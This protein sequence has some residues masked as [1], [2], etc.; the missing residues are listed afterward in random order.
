[1]SITQGVSGRCSPAS[2]ASL[3]CAYVGTTTLGGLL[4]VWIEYDAGTRTITGVTDTAGNSY[5]ICSAK[6]TDSGGRS[7]YNWCAI[8]TTPAANDTLTFTF[9]GGNSG[10][11]FIIIS[12]HISTNGWNATVTNNVESADTVASG[13]TEATVVTGT[14]NT[15]QASTLA[16]CGMVLSNAKVATATQPTGFTPTLTIAS[17]SSRAHGVW[18]NVTSVQ[19]GIT[20]GGTITSG[21]TFWSITGV[22]YKDVAA[23]SV[24]PRRALVY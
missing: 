4:N 24:H 16:T 17:A 21:G 9:S 13:T 22:V 12:E 20:C 5:S 18:A 10:T 7:Y 19:T 14:F 23:S 3:A 1:M 6:Q 8:V 2:G 15:V 11:N